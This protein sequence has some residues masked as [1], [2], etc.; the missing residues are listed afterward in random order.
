MG[1]S[2][3]YAR[4]HN[5]S[6]LNPVIPKENYWPCFECDSHFVSSEDLQKH[7]NVHDEVKRSNLKLKKKTYKNK[8]KK[9]K[10]TFDKDIIEC[11]TCKATLGY[12]DVSEIR[13]HLLTHGVST[14]INLEDIFSIIR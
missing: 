9:P 7:L 5:L 1:Y 4:K 10:K 13:Q 3:T 14:A 8:R 2:T 11:K 12:P 6:V